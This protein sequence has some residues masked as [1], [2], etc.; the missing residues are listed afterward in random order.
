MIQEVA[1]EFLH[2]LVS[3][4]VLAFVVFSDVSVKNACVGSTVYAW[5]CWR[6]AFRSSTS[7]TSAE[8]HQVWI[9]HLYLQPCLGFLSRDIMK[10][11]KLFKLCLFCV[12][13]NASSGQVILSLA[14]SRNLLLC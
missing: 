3:V 5:D 12:T 6:T 14:L 8:I 7:V 11:L 1:S 2:L 4:L 13:C 10:L 9:N